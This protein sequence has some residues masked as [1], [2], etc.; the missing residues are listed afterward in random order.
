MSIAK[1]PH[2]A[3]DQVQVSRSTDYVFEPPESPTAFTRR[4]LDELI[5]MTS[6]TK[7]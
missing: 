4:M 7:K 1:K 5:A 6:T 3:V 2:S